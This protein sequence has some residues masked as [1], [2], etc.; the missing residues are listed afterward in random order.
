ML[1]KYVVVFHGFTSDYIYGGYLFDSYKEAETF[2]EKQ[3]QY[4]K[5]TIAEITYNKIF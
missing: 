4:Q 2:I 3:N 5:Y 1:T